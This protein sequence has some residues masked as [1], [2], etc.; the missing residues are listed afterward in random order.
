MQVLEVT[1]ED[2]EEV[3][4]LMAKQLIRVKSKSILCYT[5]V[6]HRNDG[7][8]MVVHGAPNGPSCESKMSHGYGVFVWCCYVWMVSA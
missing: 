1:R 8:P 2:L 6:A 5:P 3:R 4:Q 7:R